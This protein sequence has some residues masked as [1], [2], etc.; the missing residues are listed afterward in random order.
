[1]APA[2]ADTDVPPLAGPDVNGEFHPL[3][4]KALEYAGNWLNLNGEAI[5]SSHPMPLHWNGAQLLL[6]LPVLLLALLLTADALSP[7]TASDQV[8]YTRSEDNTTIYATALSGFGSKPTLGGSALP[9]ADVVPAAGSLVYLLGYEDE[10]SRTPIAIQWSMKAGQ[11]VLQVPADIAKHPS[12][13]DPGMTFKITG[14]P[15]EL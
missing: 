8:R 7:D 15:A 5:Y 11:A 1:M 10:A 12:I 4:V 9:L 2:P 3:A 14:K 13:M 6:L